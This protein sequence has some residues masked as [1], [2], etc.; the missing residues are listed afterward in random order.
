[1]PA[2]I[3]GGLGA[4][5]ILGGAVDDIIVWNPG[6][7]SDTID[8][9]PGTDTLIFNGS[10]IAEIITIAA[11]GAGFDLSRNIAS[12]QMHVEDTEVLQVN[13]LGGADSV[14]TTGLVNTSQI[15]TDGDDGEADTLTFDAAGG[16][17]FDVGGGALQ[18]PGSQPVQVSGFPTVTGSNVVCGAILDLLSGV[19]S[20]RS[21]STAPNTLEVSRAGATYTIRDAGEGLISA[22]P[23]SLAQGC[24]TVAPDTVT[25]PVAGVVSFDVATG[26]GDDTISL[27]GAAV[28]ALVHA[29][30]GKDTIVGGAVDDIFLWNPGDASDTIDGGPGTDT[31]RFNGAI[32]SEIIA[33]TADGAG[34][35]L[36]RN[37]GSV[38]LKVDGTEVL[39]LQTQGGADDV[40]TTPLLHTAQLLTAG[41]DTSP[42]TLHV[43]GAGLCLTREN[44]SFE[45]DGRQ[46]IHFASFPDVFVSNTICRTGPVRE[47]RRHPG[48]HGERGA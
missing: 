29:G 19:L 26:N 17:V 42:D 28:P 38:Q 21:I 12:I 27:A 40:T 3:R 24:A 22:T 7:G 6:D 39:D 33:I 25:C 35:D 18:V 41:T 30:T 16:C 14:T 46:P 10:I 13:T 23:G 9:G 31:L 44:D 34:F 8:G 1:M 43:D 2:L 32:I 48:L 45:T 11:D 37:I 15:I 5:T 4:D 36:T 20:Y 47:R